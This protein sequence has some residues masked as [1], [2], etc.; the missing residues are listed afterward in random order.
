MRPENLALASEQLALASLCVASALSA[1]GLVNKP[2]FDAQT[3]NQ[4]QFNVHSLTAQKQ[5]QSHEKLT[6]LFSA[7]NVKTVS[8]EISFQHNLI[9]ANQTATLS[10]CTVDNSATLKKTPFNT[11]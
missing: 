5:T 2:A 8:D 1:H 7:D 3:L 6:T 4:T 9:N 11:S 10:E